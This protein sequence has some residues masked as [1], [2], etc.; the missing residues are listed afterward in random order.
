MSERPGEVIII[1]GGQADKEKIAKQVRFGC[2]C[3]SFVVLGV[4]LL[5]LVR[6][7]T[8]YLWF[9]HDARHPEVFA[10]AYETKAMLFIAVFIPALLLLYFSLSRALQVGMVYLR[11]PETRGEQ[12]VSNALTFAKSHAATVTKVAAVLIALLTAVG[13]QNEWN[14]WLAFVNGSSFGVK[15][16]IFS[17]DLGFFV[18]DLPW[19]LA[20]ANLVFS[21]LLTTTVLTIGI[22]VGLQALAA[23]AKIELSKPF[24]RMHICTLAGLTVL[25]FAWQI[26]LRRY[27][28]GLADSAQF[29]GAGFS[30]MQKLTM[31]S[32]VSIL[33]A[34]LGIGVIVNG[35]VGKP[36]S[37]ALGGGATVGVIYLLGVVGWS[38]F[39]QK[40]RV[41]PNKLQMERDYAERAIK[42]TRWAY[43]LD[44]IEIRDQVVQNQPTAEELKAAAPTLASMRLWDPEV[45]RQSID[46][47]QT[48]KRYY[49][50]HDVD[51]G[52]YTIDGKKTAVMLSPR[53]VD[54]QGLD[55]GARSW[56]NE[57]L[58]YTHGFG[59]VMAPVNGVSGT[60]QPSFLIRDV[61]P[62]TPS[63][64]PITEPRIYFS[65]FRDELGAPDDQYALVASNVAEFDYPGINNET[66]THHWKGG[67]GV[68]VGGMISRLAHSIVLR[69]GNLLVSGSIS[70]GTRLIYR[71]NVVERAGMIY[72]FL[73]FDTD[74]YIVL[75]DGKLVWVLDGYTFTGRIPYSARLGAGNE[76]LNYI[77]NSVKV[78]I[79]A[80]TGESKAF[81]MMPDEPL[82]RTYRKIYP[83][84][85]AD[86]SAIPAG[87]VEHL[88]YP[89]DLFTLQALQLTQYHVQE[90]VAFLQNQ[91]AWDI[92]HERD[93]N[94]N[95][96]YVRPY[97]V[98]M[99]LPGEAQTGYRL[100]LP[101]T[102][103]LKTN[104][105][106]WLSAG[107]DPADYGKLVLFRFQGE[108]L[109][110][111]PASEQMENKF[112]TDPTIADINRQF[113]N[114]QSEIIT[115]NLLVI[116]I[117]KSVLY[118]EPLFLKSR[119]GRP[120]PELKKVILAYSD[121]IVV[122]DTYED[123]LRQLTGITQEAPPEKPPAIKPGENP[124]IQKPATGVDTVKL[125]EAARLLDEADAAL[126]A[127]DFAKYGDLQK[128][129]RRLIQELAKG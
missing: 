112:N 44:Q 46:Q 4:L 87:L 65:D 100:I 2:G 122:G 96:S 95:R 45:L 79:D 114:D 18:F 118:V 10:T 15:D 3:L 56:V 93:L 81:A 88:R 57:R 90:P 66:K 101:F 8:D 43:G 59:I 62:R 85:V 120:I 94:G 6:P 26:W 42:M 21:L 82:L 69:D 109:E 68:P 117:G 53:D 55:A 36:F 41:E 7:Y 34:L 49:T 20:V 5:G 13:F 76:R 25:A 32:V 23:L 124:P 104:M 121:K 38:A 54:L 24:V 29:T 103:R 22:Y 92:A 1:E 71:R 72:P 74:P 80:Y 50:F 16:P 19:W 99:Q 17:R 67:R 27:D 40:F 107:C 39:V 98:D 77:R 47:I 126:R 125:Q 35:R 11:I 48:L 30:G 113:S 106:G 123:A 31:E 115:G 105:S 12:L 86:R 127:G 63:S 70:S 128:R 33:I 97:Y 61:P 64:L 110:N 58:A 129:A 52:R 60:G 75:L 73:R 51:L 91:D 116:P 89:E 37:F 111:I 84:L 119:S 78:T 108:S 9:L 102:P 14:T 83:G 28:A